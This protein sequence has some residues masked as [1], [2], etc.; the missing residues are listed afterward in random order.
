MN[1]KSKSFYALIA[2]FTVTVVFAY[3]VPTTFAQFTSQT[4]SQNNALEAGTVGVEIVDADG[5]VSLEPIID[6]I[7]AQPDM[8][9]QSSVIRIANTGTLPTDT[10][11]YTTNLNSTAHNLD[12]V[13]KIELKNDQNLSL[14]SGKISNLSL[15][16]ANL[17]A[18]STKAITAIITWPDDLA[19]DDNPYQGASL[20]FEFAVDSASISV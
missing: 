2:S 11:L 13:L 19:V 7:N 16:V 15:N 10:R 1:T 20:S 18:G 8:N 6:V 12:D 9:S 5:L 14:Y 4:I 3:M 17:A